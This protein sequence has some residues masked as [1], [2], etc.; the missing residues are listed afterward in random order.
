MQ[1]KLLTASATFAAIASAANVTTT[2]TITTCV[3]DVCH[4]SINVGV[5]TQTDHVT[6]TITSCSE[7]KCHKSSSAPADKTV[8]KTHI[9]VATITSCVDDVCDTHVVPA[10]HSIVTKTVSGEVTLYTTICPLTE[11]STTTVCTEN[12][13]PP[14]VVIPTTTTTTVC[15]ENCKPPSTI[16]P[17]AP[18]TT[19]GC[20]EQSCI[21]VP[22][23]VAPQKSSE[24]YVDITVTPTVT[25]TTVV[26]K[27]VTSQSTYY[28]TKA[29]VSIWEG[30]ANQQKAFVGAGFVALAALML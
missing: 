7:D 22:T 16:A 25:A 13:Q 14:V 29:S 6:A 28:T 5:V 2:E 15:T 10:T 26:P 4:T 20:T 8:T 9:T 3:E 24:Q 18:T 17:I 19:I 21:V 27:V 11:T 12:C 1:F 23:T 30:A